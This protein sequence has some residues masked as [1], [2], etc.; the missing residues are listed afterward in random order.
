MFTAESHN[1]IRIQKRKDPKFKTELC[2]T[3]NQFGSCKYGNKCHFAHGEEELLPK[4]TSSYYKNTTCKTFIE[5]GFCL[6]GERCNFKHNSEIY[7]KIE[8]EDN[9]PLIFSSLSAFYNS[10][11]LKVF[12]DITDESE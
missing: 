1:S 3:Y 6:Y 2:K 10:K 4:M 11:R 5:K 7:D 12:K 8:K 9:L